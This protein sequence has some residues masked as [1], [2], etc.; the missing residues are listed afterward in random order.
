MAGRVEINPAIAVRVA[1]VA[2]TASQLL[3]GYYF[4]LHHHRTFRE[5]GSA[6]IVYASEKCPETQF[7]CV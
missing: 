1:A 7:A 4:W 5:N 3:T 6:L 2:S